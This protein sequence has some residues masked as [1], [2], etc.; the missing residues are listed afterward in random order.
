[1]KI[2][3]LIIVFI[4]QLIIII[5]IFLYFY[6]QNKDSSQ[7]IVYLDITN[8]E[9]E[10]DKLKFAIEGINEYQFQEMNYNKEIDISQ[11][12]NTP[13]PDIKVGDTVYAKLD[14]YAGQTVSIINA[15]DDLDSINN[16][17]Y[18]EISDMKKKPFIEGKIVEVKT[19]QQGELNQYI[20][21]YGIETI[22]FEVKSLV[23]AVAKVELDSN[24]KAKLLAIY[25]ANKVIYQAN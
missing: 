6:N 17:S 8:Q 19:G 5:G 3:N 10:N 15:T 1:M 16:H 11:Y 12:D 18:Y 9:G 25:Q 7:K 14:Q 21:E 2:R 23:G 24:G 4:L 13:K 22:N 20:V